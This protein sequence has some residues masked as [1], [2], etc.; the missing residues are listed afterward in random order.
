MV[1]FLV[2]D[3]TAT[4]SGAEKDDIALVTQWEWNAA[5]ADEAGDVDF[6][7]RGLEQRLDRRNEQWRIPERDH[8]FWRAPKE[9]IT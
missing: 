6:Y 4:G 3:V 1:G 7:D 8:P 9:N 5:K 2:L